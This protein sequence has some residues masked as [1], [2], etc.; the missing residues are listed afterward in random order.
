[1]A[2]DAGGG[3]RWLAIK[4]T[5]AALVASPPMTAVHRNLPRARGKLVALDV[6]F[7]LAGAIARLSLPRRLYHL[8]DHMVRA[9][10]N[11]ALRLSEA[12]KRTLGTRRQ[13]LEAAYAERQEV[14]SA[15]A[16]IAARGVEIPDGVCESADRLGGLVYGL[17][18]SEG[19]G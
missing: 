5:L 10:D 13:H 15:L 2:R 4:G 16:L 18:R 3:A 6:A 19:H 8:R 14:Q 12:G 7:S 11:A 9:A 1:M 17:L